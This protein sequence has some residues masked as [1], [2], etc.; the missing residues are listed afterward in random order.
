MEKDMIKFITL[1]IQTQ[2]KLYRFKQKPNANI[3]YNSEIDLGERG[4]W[5]NTSGRKSTNKLYL[6]FRQRDQ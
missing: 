5:D 3:T 4:A 2:N 1:Y 6:G